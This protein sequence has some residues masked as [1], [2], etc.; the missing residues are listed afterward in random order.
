ML[1]QIGQTGQ[2]YSYR[3][4]PNY[5]VYKIQLLHLAASTHPIQKDSKALDDHADTCTHKC[6]QTPTQKQTHTPNTFLRTHECNLVCMCVCRV[7]LHVHLFECLFV[8]VLGLCIFMCA[9]G[10]VHVF[11]RTH[12]CIH[13]TQAHTHTHTNTHTHKHT[14]THIH[15]HT[16]KFSL[17]TYTYVIERDSTAVSDH[18][19]AEDKYSQH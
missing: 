16:H 3:W 5:V 1:R 17:Y 15:T 18:L 2:L 10:C 12:E 6:L 9:C 11:L 19:V 4:I 7:Y 13:Y 14:H 8:C